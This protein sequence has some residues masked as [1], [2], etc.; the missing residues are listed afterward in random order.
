MT[1]TIPKI[2]AAT[3]AR[4]TERTSEPVAGMNQYL[5]RFGGDFKIHTA[6]WNSVFRDLEDVSIDILD[7]AREP[8]RSLK[9]VEIVWP[10]RIDGMSMTFNTPR[11]LRDAAAT[12]TIS[13]M[14]QTT[15]YEILT[16]PPARRGAP[17]PH[18]EDPVPHTGS[19]AAPRS[20]RDQS[21][22]FAATA[23]TTGADRRYRPHN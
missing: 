16:S 10:L 3:S 15:V 23:G 17:E 7:T 4:R 9:P 19:T 14:L 8:L 20:A 11:P 2:G 6:S 18:G 21:A 22:E 1:S 13:D 5:T 12:T